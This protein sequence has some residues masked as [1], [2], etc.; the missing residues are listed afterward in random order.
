VIN[1]T[2]P[3]TDCRR[4]GDPLISNLLARGMVRPD[5]LFLGL[6]VSADG[7]LIDQDGTTSDS[8]YALGPA[9]KGSLWESTAVPEIREQARRLVEHLVSASPASLETHHGL[10]S[11]SADSGDNANA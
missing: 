8:L 7:A 11:A 2:A 1:C 9:R 4:L 6:D 10:V 3:E 5:P